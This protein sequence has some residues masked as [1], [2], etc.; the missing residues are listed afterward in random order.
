MNEPHLL[1]QASNRVGGS[2]GDVDVV[3]VDVVIINARVAPANAT[4]VVSDANVNVVVVAACEVA[5]NF[6]VVVVVA[7][8]R[9][10]DDVAASAAA[11]VA[12]ALAVADMLLSFL[13]HA[14]PPSS[15]E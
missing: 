13:L 2:S 1:P 15:I 12:D 5:A 7:N 9:A 4:D 11:A 8:V 6:D 14:S 10:C 3:V